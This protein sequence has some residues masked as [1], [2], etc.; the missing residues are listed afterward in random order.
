MSVYK[1]TRKKLIWSEKGKFPR[2]RWGHLQ[3]QGK[4]PWGRGW[5]IFTLTARPHIVSD[6]YLWPF[7]HNSKHCCKYIAV[8]TLKFEN[9]NDYEGEI[10]LRVF[11][12]C[13]QK[14]DSN[15][16][17]T[18]GSMESI[19]SFLVH[20]LKDLQYSKPGFLWWTPVELGQITEMVRHQQNGKWFLIKQRLVSHA[21]FS[22]GF[23]AA[24]RTA[25]WEAKQSPKQ[26]SLPVNCLMK[27]WHPSSCKLDSMTPNMKVD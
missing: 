21:D 13:S 5:G 20:R 7:L 25:A 17:Q 4:R 14:I 24:L 23:E 2:E 9:K 27:D 8:E 1:G 16:E 11:L 19:S 22:S 10:W 26:S 12:A 15:P 18:L 6:R 3:S